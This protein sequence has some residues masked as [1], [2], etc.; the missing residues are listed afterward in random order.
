M[1][2]PPPAAAATGAL[3][4]NTTDPAVPE[5]ALSPA[6]TYSAFSATP[7]ARL[8]AKRTVKD[9]LY[10]TS[11]NFSLEGTPFRISLTFDHDRLATIDLSVS[12]AGDEKGWAGWTQQTENARRAAGDW[13]IQ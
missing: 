6:T 11:S 13:W 12:V 7:A 8:F 1:S 10:A 4:L 2:T 3:R 5:Q 9:T